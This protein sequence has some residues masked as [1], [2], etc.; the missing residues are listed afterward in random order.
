MQVLSF[1]NNLFSLTAYSNSN[2]TQSQPSAKIAAK[3]PSQ[4]KA[5]QQFNEA[6]ASV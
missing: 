4:T 2:S 6:I 3:A 5:D 1:I